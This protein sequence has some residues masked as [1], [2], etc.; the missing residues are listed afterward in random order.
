MNLLHPPVQVTVYVR[1][2]RVSM[3]PVILTIK[4]S[5]SRILVILD[6]LG[7]TV[8]SVRRD[9]VRQMGLPV[10]RVRIPNIVLGSP[11]CRLSVPRSLALGAKGS[12]GKVLPRFIYANIV[13][14]VRTTMTVIQQFATIVLRDI[15]RW[16][17]V[18]CARTL[19]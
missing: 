5:V 19:R 16:S 14:P 12:S 10:P 6:M 13:A 1:T 15:F 11:R 4:E 3:E 2:V 7:K 18:V 9:M 17:S 8:I